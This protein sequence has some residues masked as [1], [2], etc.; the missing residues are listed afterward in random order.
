MIA[1]QHNVDYD[2]MQSFPDEIDKFLGN[3]PKMFE[4]TK[5]I[6]TKHSIRK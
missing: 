4:L 3:K 1:K 2:E 6:N 5:K